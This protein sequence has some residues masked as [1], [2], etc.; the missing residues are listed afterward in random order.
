LRSSVFSP[1]SC[2]LVL[3]AFSLTTLAGAV[4]NGP[5]PVNR[6]GKSDLGGSF[7]V[8][9]KQVNRALYDS[10][11]SFVCQERIDRYTKRGHG[12]R[13]GH[14]DT[15]T[16]TLSVQDGTEQYSNLRRKGRQLRKFSELGG[17][18]SEGE[19]V[20]MLKHTEQV[21]ATQSVTLEGEEEVQG[22]AAA[23]YD[24]FT[25]AA[26]SQCILWIDG[27]QYIVPLLT[28][29]WI[30]EDSSEILRISRTSTQLPEALGIAQVR[31]N[32]SLNKVNLNGRQW[33]LPTTA[34]YL[35]DYLDS[36]HNE[37][38]VINFSDYHR[39]SAETFI[40]FE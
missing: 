19:F 32:V 27:Q 40:H 20:T 26:D 33:L 5:Q 15:I 17:A 23:V 38:N 21:L 25:P 24:F 35:L 37:W 30:A 6:A 7:L 39:Y 36:K 34:E 14:R 8:N 10:L 13:A 4:P 31:W 18:W 11:G 22:K 16:A 3:S 28:R 12:I 1:L 2:S 29:V 9:A